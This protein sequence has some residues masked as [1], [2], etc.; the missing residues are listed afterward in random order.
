VLLGLLLST[1]P[2]GSSYAAAG[3][4]FGVACDPSS[5]TYPSPPCTASSSPAASSSFSGSPS[6]LTPPHRRGF[7]MATTAPDRPPP[8]IRFHRHCLPPPLHRAAHS[9][10]TLYHRHLVAPATT[11]RRAALHHRHQIC[12]VGPWPG[13]AGPTCHS[14][15]VTPPRNWSLTSVLVFFSFA[16][17]H[18]G[19]DYLQ[20][21]VGGCIL[22]TLRQ[23]PVTLHPQEAVSL[24]PRAKDRRDKASTT[25]LC[26]HSLTERPNRIQF[27]NLSLLS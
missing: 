24:P 22:I 21:G 27:P 12:W 13:Q 11:S 15:T 5:A 6:P 9:F 19:P 14:H 2:F 17:C 16:S 23:G 7:V 18:R 10:T 26:R 4:V 20:C 8:L 1:F 3:R 25:P